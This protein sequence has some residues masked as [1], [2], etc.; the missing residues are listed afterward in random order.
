MS[1]IYLY[2][3]FIS[4][5][6]YFFLDTQAGFIHLFFKYKL[7]CSLLVY[8]T[9]VDFCM[10]ILYSAVLL[11]LLINSKVLMKYLGFLPFKIISSVNRDDFTSSFL[12][13]MPFIY[14]SYLIS[15]DRT[16]SIML[17]RGGESE[18]PCLVSDLGRKAFSLS[19]F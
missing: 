13:W 18:Y 8:R 12:I 7:Y 3:E 5:I 19:S 10:L 17:N 14:F 4:L 11:N 2:I 6:F 15:L 9:T 1:F 16:S